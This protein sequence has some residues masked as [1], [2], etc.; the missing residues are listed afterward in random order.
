MAQSKYFPYNEF[1][2]FFRFKATAFVRSARSFTQSHTPGH[3]EVTGGIFK[4]YNVEGFSRDITSK[5][6]SIELRYNK[7]REEKRGSSESE[8]KGGCNS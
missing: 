4:R 5:V 6:G 1:R 3:A 7:E 8:K 2:E